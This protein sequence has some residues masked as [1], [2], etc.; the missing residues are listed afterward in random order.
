MTRFLTRLHRDQRGGSLVESLVA[1][2]L[3]GIALAVVM[4]SFATFAIGG[5]EARQV[6][7]AQAVARAQATRL[8]AAPYAPAGDYSAY[9]EPL[10]TGL[11]RSLTTDWWDGSAS[12]VGTPNA[13]GLQRLTLTI[14]SDG[15]PVATLELVKADR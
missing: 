4:G 8:K 11:S 2:A 7:V 9:F 15:K 5:S 13:N 14:R 3:L 1:S 12:W 6:A 10:P